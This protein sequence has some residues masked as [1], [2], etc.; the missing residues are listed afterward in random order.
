MTATETDVALARLAD[1]LR[2][3]AASTSD[4]SAI[5]SAGYYIRLL[6]ATPPSHGENLVR[7]IR[8]ALN[9]PKTDFTDSMDHSE[10]FRAARGA[11]YGA[12]QSAINHYIGLR[13][14]DLAFVVKPEREA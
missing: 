3:L 2:R 5:N 8:D 10:S 1:A 7:R 13:R 9:D 12:A 14:P 6:E 4:S 11:A